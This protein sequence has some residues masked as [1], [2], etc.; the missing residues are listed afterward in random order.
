MT[1]PLSLEL[2]IF[3]ARYKDL[4]NALVLQ[5]RGNLMELVDPNLGSE[6]NEEEAIRMIKVALL[7]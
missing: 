2:K 7:L 1:I 5:Q 6:F 3:L 4:T